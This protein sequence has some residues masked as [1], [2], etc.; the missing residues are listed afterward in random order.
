MAVVDTP[1]FNDTHLS[2]AQ[3][4]EAIVI[5]LNAAYRDRIELSGILYLCSIVA[6]RVG[7]SA[8]RS[9]GWFRQLT[10]ERSLRKV[11]LVTT[12]WD[13]VPARLA[14]EEANERHRQLQGT[15]YWGDMIRLGARV[16]KHNHSL[17]SARAA[18]R[19]LLS[20]RTENDRETYLD[21]QEEMSRGRRLEETTVGRNINNYLDEQQQYFNRELES[22]RRQLQ[23]A[24]RTM[25][26]QHRAELEQQRARFEE[27]SRRLQEDRERMRADMSEL[28]RRV[29]QF[30]T[31]REGERA[32][33][34]IQR[35][36]DALAARQMSAEQRIRERARIEAR[37]EVGEQ[38]RDNYWCSV[39]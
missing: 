25:T 19:T 4:L 29:Q 14:L 37:R 5:W 23:E 36:L 27:R 11:L 8:A 9:L 28:D 1:G 30:E 16:A 26:A 6:N 33:E 13:L 35:D 39:Q 18:I 38:I 31:E 3:V 24:L 10:G 12:F 21:V 15:T 20:T 2:D 17:E 34:S 7:G 22:M 32:E